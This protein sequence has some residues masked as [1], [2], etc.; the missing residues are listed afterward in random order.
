MLYVLNMFIIFF[1]CFKDVFKNFKNFL[2]VKV[3]IKF[4]FFVVR[5]ILD[6]QFVLNFGLY[7]FRK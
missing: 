5:K 2:L 6:V 1:L 7:E 4:Y 3:N